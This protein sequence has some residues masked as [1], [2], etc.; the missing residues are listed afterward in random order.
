MIKMKFNIFEGSRWIVRL[1]EIVWVIICI[2]IGTVI[3]E[4]YIAMYYET[5]YPTAPFVELPKKQKCDYT[6][7]AIRRISD[8]SLEGGEEISVILCF[9]A[10]IAANGQTVI[11]F[12]VDSNGRWWGSEKSS[13]AVTSYTEI[14]ASNFK[15]TPAQEISAQ[16]RAASE[17]RIQLRDTAVAAIGGVIMS[18]ILKFVVGWIVR[19]FLGIPRGKDK[20][21]ETEQIVP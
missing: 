1:F 21:P 16:K 18:E 5:L 2:L 8:Y 3:N 17:W 14:R 7:D 11:P 12:K 10:Q 19:G 15:L 13:Q 6:K 4:P 9:K 20:R